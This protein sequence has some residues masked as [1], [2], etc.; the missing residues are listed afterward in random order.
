MTPKHILISNQLRSEIRAGLYNETRALPTEQKLTQRFNVS[1]Q[2][3][4]LALSILANEN[5]IVK[6]QGSGTYL[7]DYGMNASFHRMH[8]IAVV[9][10]YI[11]DYIFP[12][13]LRAAQD[14]FSRSN[15]TMALYDTRNQVVR[16]RQILQ[17][18]LAQ[19]VD[20]I[21]VEGT[22]TA[23][24]SPNADLYQRFLESGTPIVFFN[25]CPRDLPN[26]ITVLDDNFAGGYQLGKY[27]LGLG[28]KKIAAFF[29][30]DDMQGLER[31][32]GLISAL[33]DENMLDQDPPVFW[34]STETIGLIVSPEAIRRIQD[35]TAVVCYNDMAAFTL[36]ELLTKA[37]RRVPEDVSVVS[38]DNSQYS[39]L[40]TVKITSL[41]HEEKNTGSI[42]A[43]KLLMLIEQPEQRELVT[44]ERVPWT[45]KIKGSS[46]APKLSAPT[47]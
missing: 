45:L 15:C 46:R 31:Y 43:E 42:A 9:T 8:S 11:S 5:L 14:V 6:R 17:N 26:P 37:G 28:H 13:I 39:E 34:Y 2:T 16:E 4:R 12:R 1:R 32:Y 19:Q 20:G 30:D 29:K 3:I 27:L 47:P 35:C 36:I 7:T 18:L 38:F 21:L 41:S 33:R 23:L 10:T 22:K 24:P 44:S 25:A 40:S